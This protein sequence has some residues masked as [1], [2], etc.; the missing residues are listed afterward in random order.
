MSLYQR[1]LGVMASFFQLGGPAGAGLKNNGGTAIEMTNPTNSGLVV[2]RGA[3]PAGPTDFVTL[4]SLSSP[5]ASTAKLLGRFE[6]WG[7]TTNGASTIEAF[8]NCFLGQSGT[9]VSVIPTSTSLL[10]STKRTGFRSLA[11]GGMTTN[12]VFDGTGLQTVWR[13]NAAGLGGFYMKLKFGTPSAPTGS[14]SKMLAGLIAQSGSGG[15]Q[16]WTTQLNIASIGVGFTEV[17]GAAVWTGNW[18]LIHSIGDG[19]TPPTV[20]DLGGT[21]P[22][23]LTDLYQLELIAIPN[24]ADITVILTNLTTGASTTNIVNANF[25]ASTTFLA[26]W[27]AVIITNVGGTNGQFDIAEYAYQQNN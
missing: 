27:C 4:G 23:N 2:G 6:Y 9:C 24:G 17:T 3:D 8:C 14:L 15:G 7:G 5:A 10:N 22:V 25:P 16:D 19:A 12:G 1:L 26:L 13:G 18:Q 11:A 20:L 21:M